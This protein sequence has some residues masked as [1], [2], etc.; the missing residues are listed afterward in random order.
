MLSR[1]I[2]RTTY[3]PTDKRGYTMKKFVALALG[4][5]L[6]ALIAGTALAA[7]TTPVDSGNTKP[8]ASTPAAVPAAAPAPRPAAPVAPAAATAPEPNGAK[9]QAVKIG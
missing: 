5:A 6:T 3:K 7:S 4:S 9:D 1:F 2:K 8:G